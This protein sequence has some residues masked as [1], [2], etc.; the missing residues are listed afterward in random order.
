MKKPKPKKTVIKE[1]RELQS[2]NKSE[3]QVTAFGQT[4]RLY[5]RRSEFTSKWVACYFIPKVGETVFSPH[6]RRQDALQTIKKMHKLWQELSESGKYTDHLTVK[7]TI[8]KISIKEGWT[9]D[10]EVMGVVVGTTDDGWVFIDGRRD[11]CS[12]YTDAINRARFS[13]E[14]RDRYPD[15]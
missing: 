5:V 6:Y 9:D 12:R 2:Q 10:E 1:L 14:F 13:Q 15:L 7:Q 4:V 3:L 8:L 11:T